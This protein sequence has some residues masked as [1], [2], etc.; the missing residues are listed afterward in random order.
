M[1][2]LDFLI[3][4]KN[5][6]ICGIPTKDVLSR[7]D[8][9]REPMC[10]Q[11]AVAEFKKAYLN[12]PYNMVV[13]D[14]YD[15]T[16]GDSLAY[17]YYSLDKVLDFQF[18]DETEKIL[19]QRLALFG[20][21]KCVNCSDEAKIY[22]IDPNGIEWKEYRSHLTE[23]LASYGKYMCNKCSVNRITPKLLTSNKKFYD[24]GGI[25]LPN[26]G[27]GMFITTQC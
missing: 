10:R 6:T 17:Y 20:N 9:D 24:C 12:S 25:G 2:I 23:R 14:Y 18:S 5:C 7:S 4:S 1:G 16:P 15:K 26:G 8:E 3:L 19:K 27:D 22:F 21:E 13:V 11:H